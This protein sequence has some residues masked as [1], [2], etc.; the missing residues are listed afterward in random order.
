VR[1]RLVAACAVTFALCAAGCG[2]HSSI[3]RQASE[4]LAGVVAQV[5]AAARAHDVVAANARL[6]DIGRM[7]ALLR[8]RG[9]VSEGAAR[10]ILAA[11]DAVRTDLRLV[12]TTTTSTSTT[13]STT[14]PPPPDKRK[15]HHGH[16]KG[17]GDNGD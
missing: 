14:S 8:A 7:V 12:A 16:G 5:R 6:D 10:R 4:Q 13:S 3:D 11:A 9:D 17:G 15:E 2:G 1:A